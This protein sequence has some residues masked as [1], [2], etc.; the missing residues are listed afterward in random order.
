MN[1]HRW[2]ARILALALSGMLFLITAGILL[3]KPL[4][5]PFGLVVAA[6]ATSVAAAGSALVLPGIGWRA[7]LW[8]SAAFLV[9]FAAVLFA[10]ILVGRPDWHPALAA[11]VVTAAACGAAELTDRSL[12]SR[13]GRYERMAP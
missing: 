6:V 5:P 3:L 9:Y 13:S 4:P 11:V 10:Y 8:G 12:G 1:G 7:G 2:A